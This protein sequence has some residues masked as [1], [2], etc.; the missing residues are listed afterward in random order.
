MPQ[1]KD[2]ELVPGNAGVQSGVRDIFVHRQK[3]SNGIR[4]RTEGGI[5]GAHGFILA[6]FTLIELLVV[7]AIIALLMSILM[8][9]LNKVKQQT[10]TVMCRS[11]LHQWGL[12]FGMYLNDHGG[13]FMSGYEW[14]E[15]LPGGS[16][17]DDDDAIDH[18]GDHAWPLILIRYYQ[19]QRL[20]RCPAATKPPFDNQGERQRKD[21]VFSTWGLWWQYPDK[22]FYG[23]Y[24]INSWVYNRGERD[25]IERWKQIQVKEAGNI[26]ML[27]DC[28]WCEGYPEYYNEPPQW[29]YYG[30]FGDS[31]NHMR[32]FCVNRHN[33]STNGLF[34]DFSVR[35]VGLKELWTLRWHQQWPM[36]APLPAWPDWMA[37]MEDPD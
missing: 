10:K 35:G 17:W 16:G 6:G 22:Y 19:D 8:P 2:L 30:E 27:L 25:G 1:S 4:E 26:P 7:I 24:G 32:R 33:G 31:D 9:A 29:D 13:R 3:E 34:F 11:N 18:T 20:L 5:C 23:S 21:H 36:N 14:E 15:L 37:G 28:Y 12:V